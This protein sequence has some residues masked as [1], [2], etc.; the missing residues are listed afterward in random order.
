MLP[1]PS[2]AKPSGL[3][4]L[5]F[6]SRAAVSA[7]AILSRAGDD[8]DGSGGGI[9]LVDAV[10]LLH[11]RFDHV[12]IAVAIH[13]YIL[14][15]GDSIPGGCNGV[16]RVGHR[17]HGRAD[18]HR[19]ALEGRSCGVLRHHLDDSGAPLHRHDGHRFAR[20]ARRRHGFIQ[21]IRRYDQSTRSF[22]G[23]P[24]RST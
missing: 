8:T 22:E 10:A 18:R 3:V 15:I 16:E 4:E 21:R 23:T 12:E 6:D 13:R 11:Q 5:S 19:D 2:T 9:H 17:G 20:R 14:G 1:W 24:A 7:V